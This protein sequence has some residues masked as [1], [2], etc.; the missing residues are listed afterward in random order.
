LGDQAAG[1]AYPSSGD[2]GSRPAEQLDDVARIAAAV[3]DVV[4]ARAT[5]VSRVVDSDWLEVLVVAGTPS[6]DDLVGHR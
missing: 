5:M 1:A 6:R 4:E 2:D 3:R